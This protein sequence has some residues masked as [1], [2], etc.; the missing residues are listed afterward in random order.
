[1]RKPG[2]RVALIGASRSVLFP[3]PKAASIAQIIKG[4][5][6]LQYFNQAVPADAGQDARGARV[7]GYPYHVVDIAVQAVVHHQ[8]P[9]VQ[10]HGGAEQNTDFGQ[11]GGI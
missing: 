4:L 1:V 7:A 8:P 3:N 10:F 5:L 11:A 9:G 6:M 2:Q